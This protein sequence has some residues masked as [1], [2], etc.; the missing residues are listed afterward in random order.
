MGN[1]LRAVAAS[2]IAQQRCVETTH[3][4]ASPPFMHCITGAVAN[5][6]Y[7]DDDAV[8]G[9]LTRQ[10]VGW[11]LS[12]HHASGGINP[13]L[14]SLLETLRFCITPHYKRN[15]PRETHEIYPE[16]AENPSRYRGEP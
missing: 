4:T 16:L 10:T 15:D 8:I 2:N 14:Q 12:H 3:P 9:D 7:Q 1:N 5:R 13:T 6:D 11:D